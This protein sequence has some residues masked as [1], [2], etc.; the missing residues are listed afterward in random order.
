MTK[1][2]KELLW[3]SGFVFVLYTLYKIYE[4]KYQSVPDSVVIPTEFEN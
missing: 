4:K 1:E 2:N 3:I